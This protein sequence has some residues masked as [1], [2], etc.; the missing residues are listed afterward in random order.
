MKNVIESFEDRKEAVKDS[1]GLSVILSKKE[2]DTLKQIPQTDLARFGFTSADQLLDGLKLKSDGAGHYM[3]RINPIKPI[4]P[5]GKT[6]DRHPGGKSQDGNDSGDGFDIEDL[7]D[8]SDEAKELLKT[9]LAVA[10]VA[11]IIGVCATQPGLFPAAVRA[12]SIFGPR[13]APA[14]F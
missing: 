2:I 14:V 13:L 6:G 8:L 10:A 3:S 4:F 12:I 7:L 9:A 1:E 11:A 5:G